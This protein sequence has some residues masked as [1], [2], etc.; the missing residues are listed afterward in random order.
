MNSMKISGWSRK[1][2]TDLNE[3]NFLLQK[4]REAV[5]NRKLKKSNSTDVNVFKVTLIACPY[6]PC[7]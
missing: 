7:P 4:L 2:S 1:R 3:R 6:H 5:G